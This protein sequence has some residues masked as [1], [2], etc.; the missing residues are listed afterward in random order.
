MCLLALSKGH[1]LGA[2]FNVYFNYCEDISP[3]FLTSL[4]DFSTLYKP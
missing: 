3:L 1:W 4:S 2:F